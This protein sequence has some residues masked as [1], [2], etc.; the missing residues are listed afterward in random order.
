MT[1]KPIGQTA[2][3][4]RERSPSEDGGRLG[5]TGS[6]MTPQKR[7]DVATWLARHSP[8]DVD[9]VAESRALSHG[10]NLAIRYE[11]RYPQGKNGER[12]PS[13]DVAVGCHSHGTEAARIAALSDLVKLLQPAPIREIE[14]WLAELSVLTA[15]R[16]EDGLN[17]ELLLTAY[18]SRLAQ[19]PADVAKHALLGRRWKW[20]PAW[21]EVENICETMAAPRRHM[22]AALQKP[23]ADEEPRRREPTQEE[24]ERVQEM[25]DSLFPMRSPEMR[26]AAVNVALSGKCMIEPNEGK[27]K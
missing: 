13:Y 9:R 12:L 24:R 22:V 16:G 23:Q 25:V 21:S 7:S 4:P 14:M 17:A 1:F 18:S 27:M 11:G 6:E 8:K 19:Y 26:K 10:V 20:F 15:G 3:T 2:P 5:A